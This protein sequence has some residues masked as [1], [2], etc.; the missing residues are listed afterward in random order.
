MDVKT[1]IIM[2]ALGYAIITLFM[3]SVSKLEFNATTKYHFF[4]QLSFALGFFLQVLMSVISD[5]IVPAAANFGMMFGGACEVVAIMRLTETYTDRKRTS[6]LLLA[7]VVSVVQLVISLLNDHSN[8]RIA[9]VTSTL[10]LMLA[11]PAYLL[12]RE[13]NKSHLQSMVGM[14]FLIIC[15]SL[16]LRVASALDFR[17]T[18][19][20]FS[21]GTGQ[22]MTFVSLFIF[23][24]LSGSGI[25][26]LLKEK[27]D[28]NLRLAK[29]EAD[30]ANK[31][32][33]EFLANVS[34]EIRTPMNAIIGFS[35]LV[36]KTDLSVKQKD[37]LSKIE[38]S[39]ISLL[40][41]INDVLDFAKIE[42]GKLEME[43]SVFQLDEVM[44]RI[45]N[46]IMVRAEEKHI[47][48]VSITEPIVPRILI[49]DSLRLGQILLNLTTNAIKFTPTGHVLLKVELVN[50]NEDLRR[51]T[52][53]FTVADSGIGIAPDQ[54]DR[55]FD[56]FTQADSS[57]TRKYGGTGLGLAIAKDLVDMMDGRISVE[58]ELGKGSAFSVV[59]AFD[60]L[61]EECAENRDESVD[62]SIIENYRNKIRGARVLLV[63]D[64]VLNQQVAV[65]IIQNEGLIADIANNGQE[66]LG[67]LRE[68]R[69]DVVLMDLQMPVMGG[70]EAT[71]LI[72][73]EEKHKDLP[74]IAISAHAM[75]FV[76]S[77]CLKVGMN[78]CISKP[79]V[80]EELISALGKYMNYG[81]ADGS[82]RH[83]LDK[84]IEKPV[85]LDAGE[86]AVLDIAGGLRRINGKKKIYRQLLNDFVKN[87]A[88]MAEH[89][90]SLIAIGEFTEAEHVL[91]NCKGIAGN[92]SANRIQRTV[93]KLEMSIVGR[94]N[95]AFE[96]LLSAIENEMR[97][98][99][100][101]ITEWEEVWVEAL[102]VGNLMNSAQVASAIDEM[103]ELI[104]RDDPTAL[105]KMEYLRNNLQDPLLAKDIAE[106]D[107]QLTKYDFEK[108]K[109]T[110]R[111]VAAS[112]DISL[113]A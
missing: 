35:G 21:G 78:D 10:C 82:E 91:H 25:V 77:A 87:Y 75:S 89:I 64:N 27:A 26:L 81:V 2:I 19:T 20:L 103:Y 93:Q 94:N 79:I 68:K 110:L 80:P 36:L 104:C 111:S 5:P 60:Y 98:L 11:I 74:I 113:G 34:H 63:E 69:Y 101:A 112:L 39:A 90:R 13:K 107:T 14:V 44:Q 38:S 32:K 40:G 58:S 16:G 97:L 108:A 45:T 106:L 48:L 105:H 56:A 8:L 70:L 67:A 96:P 52:L 85:K 83:V 22:I 62:W 50:K 84:S 28:M 18:Y 31:A 33:S 43:A 55:I 4:S 6:I 54:F 3:L 49:G 102:P 61:P 65:E 9:M 92:I 99:M 57:V 17:E 51:C 46:I 24:L 109:R 23:M 88:D 95:S 7:G 71:R 76:K 37:Y 53:K 100:E 1:I 15:I 66:A 47:E 59:L 86:V 29:E 42:A 12:L 30:A 72:R 73:A 41:L